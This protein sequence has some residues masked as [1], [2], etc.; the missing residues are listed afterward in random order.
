MKEN[1]A[2]ILKDNKVETPAY[3]FDL[4]ALERHMDM[5]HEVFDGT[6]DLCFAMKANPLLTVPMASQ[7]SKLEVCSPGEF[8]I[9]KRNKI[10]MEKIVM[11][12][13][14]KEKY[15]IDE[16]I[17]IFDGKGTFTVESVFQWLM[18]QEAACKHGKIIDVLLRLTSGNQF[19][20]DSIT[21]KELIGKRKES[22]NLHVKGIQ[23]YSGTQ[24]KKMEKL[25]EE[26]QFLDGF[27]SDLKVNYGFIAEE[28]EYGPGFFVSYFGKESTIEEEKDMLH[29]FCRCLQG[30]SYDGHITLEMGR[31]MTAGCGSF[32]TKIVDVKVNDNQ[33][34][35]VIDGGIHHINYYGQSMGMKI[36]DICHIPADNITDVQDRA[37]CCICG[38][39]CTAGDVVVRNMPLNN[40]RIG[41]ILVFKNAG[42]YSVTEGMYLF[43]SRDLPGIYYYDSEEGVKLVRAV[44][45]TDSMNDVD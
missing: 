11:S 1:F 9:C 5:L 42:A 13:V 19:G 10:P 25:M 26:I 45:P 37:T 21:I 39:L 23:L 2:D 20:C 33:K 4:D 32:L 36:P 35:L 29:T 38:S 41:D 27:L 14:N 12:G 30:M 24:K 31:Y 15:E 18:L 6:A 34:Y 44:R 8:R 43:L 3:V 28:L 17:R 7:V 40:P 22:P 16:A